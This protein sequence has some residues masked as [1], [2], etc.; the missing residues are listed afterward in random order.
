MA[1]PLCAFGMV[2]RHERQGAAR[3]VVPVMEVPRWLN[4]CCWIIA[5]SIMLQGLSVL[6]SLALWVLR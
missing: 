4:V 5:I 2:R 6:V 1:L 3:A